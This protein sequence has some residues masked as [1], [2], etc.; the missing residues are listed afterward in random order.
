VL[1]RYNDFA[2]FVSNGANWSIVSKNETEF[3][4]NIS[5]GNSVGSF[6]S[7]TYASL[8]GNDLSLGPGKWRIRGL[9]S[10]FGG[11][12]TNIYFT[13]GCGFYGAN[14]TGT[15]TPPTALSGVIS[16]ET[17]FTNIL[18]GLGVIS[19][20]HNTGAVS[21]SPMTEIIVS[22]D[23]TTSVYLVPIFIYTAAG[24]SVFCVQI[25]AERLW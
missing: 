16:G 1:T 18:A 25:T 5:A 13:P 22:F 9:I 8:T 21:T 15:G 4:N 2:T 23:T 17:D 14:G 12:G 20:L 7:N 24:G 10:G 11:G 19:G 6:T 3:V